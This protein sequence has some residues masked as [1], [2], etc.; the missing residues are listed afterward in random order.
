MS[1]PDLQM[2]KK[3][4]GGREGEGRLTIRCRVVATMTRS[5]A[6]LFSGLSSILNALPKHRSPRISIAR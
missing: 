6:N 2:G 1:D 4:K 3:G 5:S